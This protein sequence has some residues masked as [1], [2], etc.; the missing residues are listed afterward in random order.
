M[1]AH[2]VPEEI[3]HILQEME[4]APPRTAILIGFSTL[5]FAL[6]EAIKAGIPRR[7][8]MIELSALFK[9]RGM[10]AD[11]EKKTWAAYYLNI[12]GPRRRADIDTLR[13]VH[14]DCIHRMKEVSFDAEPIASRCQTL[15]FAPE[16]TAR[17]RYMIAV[18]MLCSGLIAKARNAQGPGVAELL[19]D[20]LE[21]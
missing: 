5:E 7:A 4:E 12:I 11:F 21:P 16:G 17:H 15:A 14:R 6:E 10:F 19:R 8:S 18:G 1:T 3:R 9:G 2:Y 13:V 20:G